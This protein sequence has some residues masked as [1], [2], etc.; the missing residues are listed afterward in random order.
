MT[1]TLGITNS[2]IRLSVRFVS[3]VLDSKNAP[4]ARDDGT[5]QPWPRSSHTPE[6]SGHCRVVSIP[7]PYC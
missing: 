7:L 3:N 6:K 5:I 4:K 2:D 1:R